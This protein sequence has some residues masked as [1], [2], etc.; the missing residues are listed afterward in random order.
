MADVGTQGGFVRALR[1]LN[2]SNWKQ[3]EDGWLS[4]DLATGETRLVSDL[5]RFILEALSDSA[6]PL[7]LGELVDLVLTEEPE[8]D[9]AACS[10]QV[11]ETNTA[12][13]DIGWVAISAAAVS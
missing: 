6:A 8:F 4:Y 9:R 12:L 11:A 7:T 2:A 13:L 3:V 10:A 1:A 5:A